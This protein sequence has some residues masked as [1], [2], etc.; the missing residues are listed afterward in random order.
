MYVCL[1]SLEAKLKLQLS[2]V[3][4]SVSRFRRSLQDA[5]PSSDREHVTLRLLYCFPLKLGVCS[6]A[7]AEGNDGGN[8]DVDTVIQEP[9]ERDVR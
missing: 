3:H 2:R 6:R 7:K 9:S 5:K 4:T 1:F 8:R